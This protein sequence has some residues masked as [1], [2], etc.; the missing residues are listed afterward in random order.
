[1]KLLFVIPEY[2]PLIGGGISTFYQNLLPV[3]VEQGHSIHVLVGSAF[4][5]QRPEYELD[6]VTVEFLDPKT[7]TQNLVNFNRYHA[8]PELQ[9]HL[10]AAWT[11][12]EQV[13]RGIGYDVVE[14]TDW[15]LLFVPWIVSSES[16][17]TVV[18]LHASIGQIDFHDPRI[19]GELQSTLTRLLELNLLSIADELQTYSHANAQEWQQLIGRN[20]TDIPPALPISSHVEKVKKSDSGLVVGRIQYWKGPTILCEALQILAQRAPTLD[21]LGRDTMYQEANLSMKGYLT[22]TYPDVWGSKVKDLGTLSPKETRSLQAKAGFILVPSIWDVFNYTCIEGMAQAQI[23]ICSKG[24]GAADLITDGVNGFTFPAGNAQAL[25]DQLKNVMELST[26]KRIDISQAAQR[27]IQT[28]LNPVS[29]AQQRIETYKNLLI[30][31][32]FP[33]VPNPWLLDAF[34]P[35]K[36]LAKPLSFLNHLPLGDLSRYVFERGLQKIVR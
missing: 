25:A 1:M 2:P 26:D 17:P 11:A 21:W 23:V 34:S 18:Q 20:I 29:I 28:N 36:S 32:K 7:V 13:N 15:G 22:Q 6:G 3:L 31:G 9:R 12:W 10:A 4:T 8:T 30:R 14:V 16:P 33:G 5:N 35:S 24:A 19:D 27:T